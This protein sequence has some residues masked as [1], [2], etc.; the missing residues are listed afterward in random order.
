MFLL[1]LHLAKFCTHKYIFPKMYRSVSS[2]SPTADKRLWTHKH[3]H[4]NTLCT[5]AD[6]KKQRH[7]HRQAVGE[8][9]PATKTGSHGLFLVDSLCTWPRINRSSFSELTVYQAVS[10]LHTHTHRPQDEPRIGAT[11]CTN[12]VTARTSVPWTDAFK[13]NGWLLKAPQRSFVK[14][15]D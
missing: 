7:V 8:A 2:D 14:I 10:A 4:N 15:T 3:P 12:T 5:H 6:T 9:P 13:D 1:A 11:S